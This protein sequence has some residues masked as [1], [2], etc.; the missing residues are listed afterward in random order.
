MENIFLKK[1]WNRIQN[2]IQCIIFL[3]SGYVFQK[4]RCSIT[5][6]SH[7]QIEWIKSFYIDKNIIYKKKVKI[8]KLK[9]LWIYF[10]SWSPLD[11]AYMAYLLLLG[12]NWNKKFNFQKANVFFYLKKKFQ[13]IMTK[14]ETMGTCLKSN[15]SP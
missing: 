14:I 9:F 7:I 13:N 5:F 15:L 4:I 8:K 2:Q 10:A 11:W 6:T 1:L 12:T 3:R